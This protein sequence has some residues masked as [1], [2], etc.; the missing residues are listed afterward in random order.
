M[1]VF[2]FLIFLLI[3]QTLFS[4]DFLT[5]FTFVDAA[6]NSDSVIV[7]YDSLATNE[8]NESFDGSNIIANPV[9]SSFDVRIS[10]AWPKKYYDSTI[11]TF[12]TKQKT[13]NYSCGDWSSFLYIDVHADHWPVRVYW[14]SSRFNDTC[15]DGSIITNYPLYTYSPPPR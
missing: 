1:K 7:G 9:S 5:K 6:G 12:Q 2:N 8:Y 11:T 10:D 14:D 4:Q 15:L 13:I 3:S